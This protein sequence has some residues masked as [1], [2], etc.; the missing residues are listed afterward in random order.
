MPKLYFVCA[1]IKAAFDSIPTEKLETIISSL[2]RKQ[3]Y[4]ML[5]YRMQSALG[6][7]YATRKV[8]FATD[9]VEDERM[10]IAH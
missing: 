4:A 10:Y 8:A 5:K 3:E 7:R 6:N 9:D 1:D 2:F